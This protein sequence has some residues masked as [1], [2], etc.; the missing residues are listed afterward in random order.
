M[1]F[2]YSSAPFSLFL[3]LPLFLFLFLFFMNFSRDLYF[4]TFARM[5]VCKRCEYASRTQVKRSR[6]GR[7][8]SFPRFYSRRLILNRGSQ[9]RLRNPARH[10]EDANQFSSRGSFSRSFHQ[11]RTKRKGRSTCAI[12]TC[13]EYILASARSLSLSY[14]NRSPISGFPSLFLVPESN[15]K[16]GKKK[17][18]KN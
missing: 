14:A 1:G 12:C 4:R 9:G 2:A 17:I 5:Y 18:R 13:I 16:R 8:L 10:C 11:A 15:E 6:G 3:S 7:H